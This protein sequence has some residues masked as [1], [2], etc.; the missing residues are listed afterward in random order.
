MNWFVIADD[1]T[2]AAEI[3]GIALGFG[4][5]VRFTTSVERLTLGDGVTVLATDTRSMPRTEAVAVTERIVARLRA[6]A[7]NGLPDVVRLFKKTDSVLRGHVTA[8][9]RALMTAGYERALLLP[10]NPSK[11]RCIV[12]GRY[13]LG[14]EPIDRTVFRTDPEFPAA[15][16]D[17]VELLGGGVHYVDSAT[18]R[19]AEGISIGE[20]PSVE[21]LAALAARFGCDAPLWAGAADAF[22]VLLAAD[23]CTERPQVPFAGFGDRRTLVVCGSTVR[24]DLSAEP[25]FRRRR[26]AVAPMPDAVFEG[27]EPTAWIA[28]ARQRMEAERADALLLRIPQ[29]VRV[30][31]AR[32]RRLRGAMARTVQALVAAERFEEVVIEGGATAYAVLDALGWHDFVVTDAVAAGV[33]RLRY[34]AADVHL[35]FKPGS[36]DWGAAFR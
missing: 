34:P 24:H 23:G 22:R 15:T 17:V 21:A 12:G 33:V 2:G 3:A 4:C 7:P 27:A 36:Y 28:A 31:G 20:T 29:Q 30:D 5:R 18:E 25:F 32:A 26:V 8:E 35:T 1:I 6:A 10:A 13:L 11:G 16:A 19:L 14:G 9:L